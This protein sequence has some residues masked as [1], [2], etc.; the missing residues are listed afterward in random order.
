MM[1]GEATS[2]EGRE[3]FWAASGYSLLAEDDAGR[4]AVTPEFVSAWLHRPEMQP[5]ETS[6]DA[7]I[8]LLEQLKADP[9]RDV[10]DAELAHVSDADAVDNFRVFLAFRDHLTAARTVEAAYVALTSA[11]APA[12]PAIFLD[13][14]VH[15]ILRHVLRTCSDPIR[16]R[17]S[18]IFFREQN[19]SL[20]DGR[21]MLADTEVVEL[22][23][24]NGGLGSLGQL[25][26]E[27]GTP[28]KQVELDVLAE[29]NA[30]IYWGRSD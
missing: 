17:A 15:V 10:S 24:R 27:S 30:A 2:Q 4:L 13:Q 12:M 29:E 11:G 22:Y 6:C 3:T 19:V 16:L 25:L 8:A 7:E 5:I 18:E 9:L 28:Q 20:D 14:L 23:A 1:T 21:V 26:A